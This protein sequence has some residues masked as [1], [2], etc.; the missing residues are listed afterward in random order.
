VTTDFIGNSL[1]AGYALSTNGGI[2]FEQPA[3]PPSDSVWKAR[4]PLAVNG[5]HV[6]IAAGAEG[7]GYYV[8]H[9]GGTSFTM[10]ET[11]GALNVSRA[12]DVA[13]GNNGTVYLSTSQG[14][15]VSTDNGDTFDTFLT[16]ANGL[17]S[18]DIGTLHVNDTTI[19]AEVNYISDGDWGLAYSIDNGASFT[20]LTTANGLPDN[21]I[22]SVDTFSG[23]L[24]V[25]TFSGLAISADQ[26]ASFI[27]RT[28]ADGLGSNIPRGALYLQ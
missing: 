27:V 12:F 22:K 1:T 10:H 28:D 6:Y 11:I 7:Y 24:Y 26:G 9:D 13:V 17:G 15:A 16:T 8:S 14:I 23:Y 3:T 20:T 18:N 4:G 21:S 2:S 5:S 19:F 25:G